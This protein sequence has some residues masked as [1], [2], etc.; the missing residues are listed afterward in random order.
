M[1]S[2]SSRICVALAQPCAGEHEMALDWFLAKKYTPGNVIEELLVKADL[3]DRSK[4]RHPSG[5]ALFP[6]VA[7]SAAGSVRRRSQRLQRCRISYH[8][9]S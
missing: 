5:H 3:P 7:I 8:H 2:E 9:L 4:R 1:I 6:S